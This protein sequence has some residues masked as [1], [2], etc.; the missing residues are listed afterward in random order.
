MATRQTWRAI[1]PPGCIHDGDIVI[2]GDEHHFLS[3]VLRVRNSD[4][5][6]V[7]DGQGVR[8][9]G[10]I[11]Q[12]GRLSTTIRC[13]GVGRQEL[14]VNPVVHL[15]VGCPKPQA[16]EELV[17]LVSEL[18]AASL[19]CVLTARSQ[20]RHP[21]RL[22][23]L[24]RLARESLRITG[25]PWA[26]KLGFCNSFVEGID[27]C[28]RMANV[29]WL[30]ADETPLVEGGE[31]HV[32]MSQMTHLVGDSECGIWIGPE[33]SFSA[34]ERQILRESLQARSVGL[35]PFVLRVPTAATVALVCLLMSYQ[36]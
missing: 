18:G 24:E 7:L 20:V 31:Q 17:V 36:A 2:E 30:M 35:G 16:L 33:S 21:P 22:D 29:S 13:D 4:F 12:V 14:R 11:V 6:E 3:R 32:L 23:R 8:V 25:N 15:F 26:T 28:K 9:S 5:V 34:E 27:C 10:Q 19:T 1:V